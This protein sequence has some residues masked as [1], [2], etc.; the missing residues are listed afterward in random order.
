MFNLLIKACEDAWADSPV[1]FLRSRVGEYTVDVIRERYSEFNEK[2]IAELKSLPTLFVTENETA[3]SKLGYISD[4]NVLN[5]ELKIFFNFPEDIPEIPQGKIEKLA[6]KL[7]L[8]AYELFRTHWAIKDINLLQV[9]TD[10]RT[11]SKEQLKSYS[12][13]LSQELRATIP[14]DGS[15]VI[16]R[17][18][19]F[20]VHGHDEI[21]KLNMKDFL[22]NLGLSPIILH[23]QASSGKTIIEKIEEYTD[24]S[25]GVVLYT[26]CDIG[27]KRDSLAFSRRAR[28]NVVFEH[29][30]LIAKLGRSKV[31]AMVKGELETPNDISGVVYI[32]MNNETEWKEALEKE[33]TTA[34]VI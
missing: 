29:G 4:I 3:P 22:E 10:D 2:T 17:P 21:A 6:E 14:A 28:Q 13:R 20:V 18:K 27:A 25:Y 11:L 34:G 31:A 24:V 8:D 30:Y 26:P 5:K 16:N 7:D 33:L 1:T 23:M 19:V 12:E 32:S 9:L 15:A